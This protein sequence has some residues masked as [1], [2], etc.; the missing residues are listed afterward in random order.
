V[1]VERQP[2]GPT[3]HSIGSAGHFGNLLMQLPDRRRIAA[4]LRRLAPDVVHAHSTHREALGAI[5][6]GLPTVVT[7][8]GMI[9]REI[10]LERRLGRRIRGVFRRRVIDA[11]FARMRHVI[12]LSSS[13]E[14]HY[15]DRLAGAR[16]WVIE[17]PVDDRFFRG[18]TEPDARTLLFSG[19]VIPRK[20]VRNLLEAV[21]R[22]RQRVPDVRL[23]VAGG[24][25]RPEYEAEVHA[26]VERLGLADAVTFLGPL[27][28][29]ELAGEYARA[30]VMVLVSRQETL[31]VAIQ[32][33]MAA[34]RPVV[35]SPVGGIPHLVREG[36]T[37]YLVPHG[38][39][40]VLAERLGTL[41]L[42]A[43]LSRRFGDNGRQIA[44]ERFRLDSVSRRTL[45]VYREVMADSA[46]RRSA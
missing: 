29:E 2:G 44:E 46:G 20:G 39:P 22:V 16:T 40:G 41:L 9:E 31:P 11:V 1:G 15:R 5:E 34:G 18:G 13:V 6:S 19:L 28:P 43:D 26:T 45:D 32:E 35:S 23:R 42:D 10:A 25:P 4:V 8:H 24:A 38:E 14:E 33:A 3:V 30:A 36:E 27:S 7:I 21:A 12:V 17:N 37:G